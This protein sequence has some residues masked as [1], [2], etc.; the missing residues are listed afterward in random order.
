MSEWSPQD[1]G[2]FFAVA[3]PFVAGVAA[4]IV[5]IIKAM[6]EGQD[7]QAASA[8]IGIEQQNR[9]LATRGAE[10]VTM[11]S[12]PMG[13]GDGRIDKQVSNLLAMAPTSPSTVSEPAPATP[14]YEVP[15]PKTSSPGD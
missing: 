4:G 8:A 3:T 6:R 11:Q 7:K 9:Y 5:L 12:P 15:P 13:T 2:V 14:V 1:W 10:P